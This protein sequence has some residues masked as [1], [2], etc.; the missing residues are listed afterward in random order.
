[1]VFDAEFKMDS[2][3]RAG[4]RNFSKFLM[5]DCDE[6]Y[7]RKARALNMVHLIKI[8]FEKKDCYHPIT[9]I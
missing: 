6:M 5:R 4:A 2:S 8:K 7:V 9:A 1:M 3:N